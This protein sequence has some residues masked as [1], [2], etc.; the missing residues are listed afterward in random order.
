MTPILLT[1]PE[2]K[3]QPTACTVKKAEMGRMSVNFV[4]SGASSIAFRLAAKN[5]AWSA[6]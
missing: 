4:R 1:E 6:T 2:H 5:A 3:P